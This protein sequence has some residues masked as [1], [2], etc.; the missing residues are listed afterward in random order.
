MSKQVTLTN[1]YDEEMTIV[2]G[3]TVVVFKSDVVNYGKVVKIKEG[4]W[5]E[6][7]LEVEADGCFDGEYIGGETRTVVNAEDCCI[8]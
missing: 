2:E 8:D 1:R 4:Y 3:K 5:G 6:I 7:E